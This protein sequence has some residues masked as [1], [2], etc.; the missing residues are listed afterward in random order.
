MFHPERNGILKSLSQFHPSFFLGQEPDG[1][2]SIKGEMAL[3]GKSSW[4]MKPTRRIKL[5]TKPKTISHP[6]RVVFLLEEDQEKAF[7]G[8]GV[9]RQ[10]DLF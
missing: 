10:D 1:V 5:A 4:I 9:S 3:V 2:D 6:K 8:N 7:H